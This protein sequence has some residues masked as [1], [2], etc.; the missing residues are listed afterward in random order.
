MVPAAELA[1][2]R[3]ILHAQGIEI[4]Y[5]IWE[6]AG[7]GGGGGVQF[8]MLPLGMDWETANHKYLEALGYIYDG[9]WVFTIDLTE[10]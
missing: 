5:E 10:P 8:I 1:A 2:A 7:G 6:S 4:T 3:E 9:P